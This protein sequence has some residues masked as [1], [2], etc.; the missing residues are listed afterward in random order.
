MVFGSHQVLLTL[1]N[2]AVLLCDKLGSVMN[3]G[4]WVPRQRFWEGPFNRSTRRLGIL[5]TWK[6]TEHMK[7][8]YM[9]WYVHCICHWLILLVR[10]V[11]ITLC[12]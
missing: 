4:I 3:P 9:A 11:I 10:I 2:E 12:I 6:F 5:A 8:A 7:L 1:T